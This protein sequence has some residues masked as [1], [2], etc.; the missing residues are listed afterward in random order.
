[1]SLPFGHED[2][3]TSELKTLVTFLLAKVLK[4]E[5]TITAQREKSAHSRAQRLAQPSGQAGSRT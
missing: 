1:M 4:L 5:R 3:S 2:L